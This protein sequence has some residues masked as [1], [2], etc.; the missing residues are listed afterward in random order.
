MHPAWCGP[1]EAMF[2]CYKNLQTT[3]VD[4]FEKRVDIILVDM[5]KLVALNN[6]HFKATSKPKIL[7][8]LEGK[9]IYQVRDG[10]NIPDL[11]ESVK[12]NVPYIWSLSH[13]Y[14]RV[15]LIKNV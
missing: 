3:V 6:D 5:E 7:L 9:I 13:S 11:E 4:E 8:A 12:K 14:R 15:L 10:P 1:T 2:P